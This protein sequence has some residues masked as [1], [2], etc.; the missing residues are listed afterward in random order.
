MNL[1]Q[2]IRD[3]LGPENVV[4]VRREDDYSRD[5][6]PIV[7][8]T[9]VTAEGAEGLSGELLLELGERLRAHLEASGFPIVSYVPVNDDDVIAAE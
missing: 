1:E 7:R 2:I 4:S 3:T 9:V 5:D 8:L 6:E